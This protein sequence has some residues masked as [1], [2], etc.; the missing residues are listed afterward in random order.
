MRP[1]AKVRQVLASEEVE[2]VEKCVMCLCIDAMHSVPPA[3]HGVAA[4]E[5]R[6]EEYISSVRIVDDCRRLN[7]GVLCAD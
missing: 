4:E 2:V 3:E 1:L 7:G 5:E 6:D